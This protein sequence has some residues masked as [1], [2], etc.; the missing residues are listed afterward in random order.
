[1][2]R[3]E[4]NKK[5]KVQVEIT[6]FKNRRKLFLFGFDVDGA[7]QQRFFIIHTQKLGHYMKTNNGIN[8]MT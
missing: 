8:I 5:K 2:F 3:E 6:R 7:K 4:N 1:L